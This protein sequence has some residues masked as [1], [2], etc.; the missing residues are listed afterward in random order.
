MRGEDI[1]VKIPTEENSSAMHVL[2]IQEEARYLSA[3]KQQSM[4]L[5]DV[6]SQSC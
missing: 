6:A 4:D 5:H 3:A 1:E 2:S